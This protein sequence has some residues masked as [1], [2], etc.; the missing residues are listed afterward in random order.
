[1][2]KARTSAHATADAVACARGATTVDSVESGARKIARLRERG[3][4]PIVQRLVAKGRKLG[5][6]LLRRGSTLEI[7]YA[8]VVLREY[9]PSGGRAAAVRTAM[10]DDHGA[11]RAIALCDRVCAAAG[12]EGV[13]H[14]EL[15]EHAGGITL[16]ELN[17]R[18][19]GT[20]WFRERLGLRPGSAPSGSRSGFPPYPRPASRSAGRS[21]CCLWK[22][23]SPRAHGAGHVS[24]RSAG[25]GPATG[26]TASA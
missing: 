19:S 8:H 18:L 12:Y 25:G 6:V 11:I 21:M 26:S 20:T 13:I 5:V 10:R 16:I 1:M 4:E 15:L 3:F 24:G 9:P 17:P 22:R 7:A 23:A 2:V 14:A